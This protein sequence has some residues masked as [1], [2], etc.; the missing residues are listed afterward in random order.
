MGKTHTLRV[1]LAERHSTA[2]NILIQTNIV[3]PPTSV[4]IS[5]VSNTSTNVVSGAN[6]S[7]DKAVDSMKTLYSVVYD[8]NKNPMDTSKYDCNNVTWTIDGVM[9]GTGCSIQV[10]DGVKIEMT[11]K[12]PEAGVLKGETKMNV[13][14]LT[15]ASIHIQRTEAPKPATDKDKSDNVYFEP[16][17]YEVTVYA[18]LR[19]KYGNF[20]GYAEVKTVQSGDRNNWSAPNTAQWKSVDT[21]V[22]TVNPKAGKSTVVHKEPEGAGTQNELIVTYTVYPPGCNNA[23]C[24]VTL[25]DTVNVGIKTTRPGAVKEEAR[26]SGPRIEDEQRYAVTPYI[27]TAR[28]VFGFS[29]GKNPASKH[30][31]GG[32]VSFFWDGAG[33]KSG[34]LY[35]YDASGSLV[36]KI[37]V[38]SATSNHDKRKIGEWD[39]TDAKGRAVAEGSY[40][41]SGTVVGKSGKRERVSVVVGVR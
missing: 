40:V 25:A 20:A 26:N 18:V 13:R 2:S 39:L 6:G 3:A 32:A 24:A 29:M 37:A 34:T 17:E 30:Y 1:F 5:T 28:G 27:V 9:V 41:V 23:S 21:A 33:I 15:P 12:D 38:S 11:Y 14:A 16:N 4:G 36:K 8:D 35:V 31:R 22:A 19:D 7:F 10:K